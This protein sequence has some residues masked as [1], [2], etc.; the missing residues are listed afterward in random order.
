MELMIYSFAKGVIQLTLDL[1]AQ[2][3]TAGINA[4][5]AVFFLLVPPLKKKFFAQPEEYQTA[6]RGITS[7]LVAVLFAGGSCL[8]WWDSLTCTKA[9]IG[10]FIG[11]VV[12]ASI[13]GFGASGAIAHVESTNKTRKT[14][15]LIGDFK[16]KD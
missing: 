2:G 12:F 11:T 1:S 4:L 14:L 16:R 15:A 8:G 5:I 7:I 13:G 6:W 9:D 3:W 10:S